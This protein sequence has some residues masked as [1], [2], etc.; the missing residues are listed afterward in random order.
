MTNSTDDPAG[1]ASWL[2]AIG[3]YLG[4]AALTAAVWAI[5]Q[6]VAEFGAVSIQLFFGAA[7]ALSTV[8]AIPLP[9]RARAMFIAGVLTPILLGVLFFAWL[10]WAFAHSDFTF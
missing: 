7:A 10:I 2:V 8:I 4:G 6:Q 3:C 9:K 5:S 1:R